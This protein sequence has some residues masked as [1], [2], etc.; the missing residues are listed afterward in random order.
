[1]FVSWCGLLKKP[2]VSLPA[3]I[4]QLGGDVF[5]IGYEQREDVWAIEGRVC[6]DR[7]LPEDQPLRSLSG[8]APLA[9]RGPMG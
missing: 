4:G 3:Y 1:M 8:T 2:R 5:T 7:L 6:C 9:L